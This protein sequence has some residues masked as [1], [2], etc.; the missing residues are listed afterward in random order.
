MKVPAQLILRLKSH[1]HTLACGLDLIIG[2]NGWIWIAK[3]REASTVEN[4]IQGRADGFEVTTEDM[5]SDT[6]EVS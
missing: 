5:Y 2:I 6:N 3:R 1:F 4:E